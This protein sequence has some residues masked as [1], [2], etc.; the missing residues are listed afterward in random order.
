MRKQEQTFGRDRMKRWIGVM[1]GTVF[2]AAAALPVYGAGWEMRGDDWYYVKEDGS[3]LRNGYVDG[4]YLSWTGR[5]IPGE[6]AA[7]RDQNRIIAEVIYGEPPLTHYSGTEPGH[8]LEKRK[9]T[10]G[11]CRIGDIITLPE[12]VMGEKVREYTVEAYALLNAF[13]QHAA[14]QPELERIS[15]IHEKM[16]YLLDYDGIHGDMASALHFEGAKCDG[17]ANVFAQ[18]CNMSG[19]DCDVIN[20]T[21]LGLPY[22][23]NRVKVDERWYY[24][25]IMYDDVEKNFDR[26]LCTDLW[27]GYVAEP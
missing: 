3:D 12:E 18:F 4:Y 17:Y 25:D 13:A 1:L 14:M 20:G 26:Y 10:Y 7:D 24:I 23:W 5:M 19:L 8:N 21:Y 6:D 22:T 11:A 16:C 2:A 15:L 27:E 9:G